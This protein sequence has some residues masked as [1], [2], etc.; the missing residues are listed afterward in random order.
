MRTTYLCMFAA[1]LVTTTVNAPG[2]AGTI[3]MADNPFAHPSTLPFETPPFDRIHDSDYLPAFRAGMAAQ[4]REV[5]AIAAGS[6]C[7]V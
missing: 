4:L 2:A 7:H 1:G 6:C 3:S 5:A